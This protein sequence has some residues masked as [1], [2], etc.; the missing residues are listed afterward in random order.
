MG[1]QA[2]E[3]LTTATTCTLVGYQTGSSITTGISNTIVG[4]RAFPNA[5]TQEACTA[6]GFGALAGNNAGVGQNTAIGYTSLA[7]LTSGA[8]NSTLGY[9]T[10]VGGGGATGVTTGNYNVL[11]GFN[12]ANT[13]T[14]DETSNVIINSF[15]VV[16]DDNTLRIGTSTGTGQQQLNRAFI[17]GIRGITTANADAVAVLVDSA[18]QMSL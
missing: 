10:G 17:C 2:G 8:F 9:N 14:S 6:M 18:N 12:A 4:G 11:I 15:G 7:R 5:T 3:D 13:F 16:S 1:T